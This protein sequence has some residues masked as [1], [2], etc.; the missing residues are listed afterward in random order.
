MISIEEHTRMNEAPF[1]SVI[2]PA[3]NRS[4]FLKI[5]MES[6]LE[7]T[8]T[9]YELIIV[10]D[11]STDDSRDLIAQY[12]PHPQI[13]AFQQDHRGVS[14]ARNLGLRH[15]RG[16]Y[17][18]FLDSDDRFRTHKLELMHEHIQNF[19]EYR[20]FHTEEVWYRNGTLLPQKSYHK[21]PSGWVFRQALELCCISISTAAVQ[22]GIFQLLGTFDE[23][24]PACEDYDFWL[25]VS[26]KFP[27]YLLPE[28]LTIKEGGHPDQQSRRYPAMDR[29]RIQALH[30]LFVGKTRL[31]ETQKLLAF[32]A[33]KK[34]VSIFTQGARKR[35]KFE[36]AGKYEAMT[37]EL[38]NKLFESLSSRRR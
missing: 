13:N 14:A 9:D 34:K 30:N 1:F 25:R 8:F 35:R 23:N 12:L 26:A 31:T 11:G 19:P 28:A 17:V 27:V 10:D 7:Q 33:L 24:L 20:V 16:E 38:E 18:C 6:V 3:Y 36:E 22:K 32:D 37:A 29:F 2:I 21:K 4:D 5:A 15:A